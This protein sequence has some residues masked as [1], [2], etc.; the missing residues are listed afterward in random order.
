MDSFA[1]VIYR[2]SAD[3]RT[4]YVGAW[5]LVLFIGVATMAQAWL[6]FATPRRADGRPKRRDGNSGHVMIDFA[7]QW[8]LGRMIVMGQGPHLYH[9]NVQ[10]EILR[11]AYPRFDEIP[12]EDRTPAEREKHDL[13]NIMDWM[14]GDDDPA[15]ARAIGECLWP[16]A[17]S[18]MLPS[19]VNL[20]LVHDGTEQRLALATR[21]QVGGPLYP[22]IHAC[23]M[24][25]LGL[26]RPAV[27]YRLAQGIELF[28]ALVA[29]AAIRSLSGGRI[30]WPVATAVI[31]LY[32]GFP[33]CISLGQN[34][35]LV[36]TLLAWGW[37]L[38]AR[39]HPGWGGLLW[40]LLAFKPVWAVAFLLVP[41]WTR[42]WRFLLGMVATGLVLS[43]A[44]LPLVSWRAWLDWLQVGRLATDLYG[45]DR[46]WIF[47][48]RDL[49][50]IPRRWL[51]DFSHL[52]SEQ[53]ELACQVIGTALL[54]GVAEVT[55]R[56]VLLRP[57]SVRQFVGPAAGL[58]LLAAWLL[59]FHF[60]FYDLLLT[61]LPVL[62]L[63]TEPRQFLSPV[64]GPLSTDS[65]WGVD[66]VL[67][68]LRP[69]LP[70]AHPSLGRP[71]PPAFRFNS[72][73]LTLIAALFLFA[74][75]LP[76]VKATVSISAPFLKEAP[77]P[78]P[79]TYSTGVAGT[80]WDTFCLLA[81]WLWCAWQVGKHADGESG[82]KA[83]LQPS[84]GE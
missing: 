46:N 82:P 41:L 18:E 25:P 10:R 5:L 38:L 83:S 56:L 15:A 2:F 63:L 6:A 48:S 16:L 59:C 79:V 37:A 44:T 84:H 50:S 51:L 35:I 49:L 76:L 53:T 67:E 24:A 32:P 64:F 26:L 77:F 21:P 68:Y 62:L 72:L 9:R 1:F 27:A 58:L 47:L 78:V 31:L 61:A 23:I 17:H 28:L 42:R 12:D 80:P 71:M 70:G 30:W 13:E 34:S 4:R 22:P 29:G 14:V 75:V 40:G 20:A 45:L 66:R 19:L 33:G 43:L 73:L 54:V 74:N 81:I 8:L 52:P 57:R 36:L 65:V 39:G 7:G 55:T 11:P 60:M 69:T 3:R